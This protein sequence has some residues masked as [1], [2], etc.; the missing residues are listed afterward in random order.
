M[1]TELTYNKLTQSHVAFLVTE[2]ANWSSSSLLF[3][4]CKHA[5]RLAFQSRCNF[6]LD[7]FNAPVVA[8]S[9]AAV[10]DR[11]PLIPGQ[12]PVTSHSPLRHDDVIMASQCRDRQ[13]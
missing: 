1:E 6:R 11:S 7:D 2:F 12:L 10:T 4:C 9:S 13:I 5:L 3:V 8:C